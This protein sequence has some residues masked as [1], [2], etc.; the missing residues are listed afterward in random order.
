MID[1]MVNSR[2][3]LAALFVISFI[4]LTGCPEKGRRLP[5]RFSV[6]GTVTFDGK[7]IDKGSISFG[8]DEDSKQGMV[9]SADIV[10]GKYEVQV[11]PGEKT[12]KINQI[13][14]IGSGI[15]AEFVNRIPEKFNK[16]ST[17]SAKVDEE[18]TNFDFNLESK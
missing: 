18:N 12:V 4:S 9:G 5:T 16:R 11:I 14:T 13:E 10:D 17:L 2:T 15:D 7:L 6:T 3:C 8:S 1:S